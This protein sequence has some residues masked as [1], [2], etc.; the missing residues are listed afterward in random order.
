MLLLLIRREK[1]KKKNG[2]GGKKG[3]FP[4]VEITAQRVERDDMVSSYDL[5]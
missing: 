4:K 2:R 1:K 3:G 5:I